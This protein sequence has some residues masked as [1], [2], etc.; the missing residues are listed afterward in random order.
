MED[1]D[2]CVCVAVGKELRGLQRDLSKLVEVV[3]TTLL[4]VVSTT[5]L[6]L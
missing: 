2:V 6:L 1:G 4:Q 3:S 5:L